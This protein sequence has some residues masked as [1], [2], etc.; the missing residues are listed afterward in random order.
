V[1]RFDGTLI[2]KRLPSNKAVIAYGFNFPDVLSISPYAAKNGVPILL[3]RTDKVPAETLSAVSGKTNTII[4]GSTGAVNDSVMKQFPKPVRYGGQ[5]RFDTGKEI[6]TKLPMG[7]GK[8]YIATGVTSQMHLL[9]QYWQR[10]IM[11]QYY[12]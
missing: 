7:T 12:W 10:E 9:D 11:H 1:N 6:I 2:A 5:T 8:A 4:V 3:T